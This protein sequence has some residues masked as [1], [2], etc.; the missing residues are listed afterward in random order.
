M[1]KK[2]CPK[3]DK[4]SYSSYADG[5]WICPTCN[6]DL[7]SVKATVPKA[8]KQ[9]GPHLFIVKESDLQHEPNTQP[10]ISPYIFKSFD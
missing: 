7:T 4:V 2:L 8:K 5:N 6:Q 1:Y 9:D 3:C 10:K